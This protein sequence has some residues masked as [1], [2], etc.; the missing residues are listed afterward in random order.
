MPSWLEHTLNVYLWIAAVGF[1]ICLP[2]AIQNAEDMKQNY[3]IGFENGQATCDVTQDPASDT[4][5]SITEK[6]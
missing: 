2:W 5:R 6:P 4:S 3:R 1:P